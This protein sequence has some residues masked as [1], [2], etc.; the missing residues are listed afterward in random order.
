[1]EAGWM[2]LRIPRPAALLIPALRVVTR[3]CHRDVISADSPRSQ[4]AA[5]LGPAGTPHPPQPLQDSC[6]PVSPPPSRPAPF[7]T[8][9]ARLGP[10]VLS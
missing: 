4:E 3:R 6:L 7:T 1:M 9:H 5:P 2:C 8:P 10:Q